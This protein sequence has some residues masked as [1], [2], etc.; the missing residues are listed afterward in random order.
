MRREPDATA[1]LITGVFG[2]GKTSVA[3]EMADVLEKRDAPYAVLD[4]DWL[5]WANVGPRDEGAEHRMMLT[6]LTSVA[7]TYLA[8][9]ARYL[10]LARWIRTRA[11]L[12]SLAE[13]I[14][15]P[16]RV[17]R[18]TVPLEEIEARLRSDVTT[19]RLDDLREAAAGFA[20]AEVAGLED[21]TV[22]NDRPIRQVAMEILGWLAWV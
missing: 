15:V 7:G 17:V 11:E 13:V 21:L 6:N 14:R 1:V 8:A 9:G 5:T 16:L 22:A 2:C 12:D 10:V 20:A 19:G 18:L 3:A 4:L